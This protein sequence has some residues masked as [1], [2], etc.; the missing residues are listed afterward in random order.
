M[1]LSS[2]LFLNVCKEIYVLFLLE[3]MVLIK[4]VILEI[5]DIRNLCLRVDGGRVR[6]WNL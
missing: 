5:R 6:N 2:F 3:L 4:I 1:F